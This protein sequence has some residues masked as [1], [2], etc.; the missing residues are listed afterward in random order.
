MTSAPHSVQVLRIGAKLIKDPR[1]DQR[2]ATPNATA[3]TH[4]SSFFPIAT[5]PSRAVRATAFD[6]AGGFSVVVFIVKY[7][8]VD[9]GGAELELKALVLA[10]ARARAFR[11]GAV[12]SQSDV[13]LEPE[14]GL[15]TL[16]LVAVVKT[17]A[18]SVEAL[19]FGTEM[20]GEADAIAPTPPFGTNIGWTTVDVRSAAD[21]NASK[22]S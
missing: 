5:G 12:L 14:L 16:G 8:V 1:R 15:G 11:G 17:G 9:A 10:E 6:F 20:V 18:E 2:S 19:V 3:A 21:L 13:K 22:S 4:T 7:A